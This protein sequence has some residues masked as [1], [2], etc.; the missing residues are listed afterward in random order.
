MTSELVKYCRNGTSARTCGYESVVMGSGH[1]T[2]GWMYTW[3]SG[4]SEVMTTQYSGSPMIS[5]T[6]TITA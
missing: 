2:G 6:R 5:R 4:L 3:L 1:H